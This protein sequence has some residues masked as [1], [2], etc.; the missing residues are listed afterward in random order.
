MISFVLLIAGA[1]TQALCGA[2]AKRSSPEVT[3]TEISEPAAGAEVVLPGGVIE[4]PTKSLGAIPAARAIDEIPRK[5]RR[6][7]GFVTVPSFGCVLKNRIAGTLGPEA[8]AFS[9]RYVAA[10]ESA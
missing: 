9:E 4:D 3:H 1:V 2:A 5:S 6:V 7:G 8:L 10:K